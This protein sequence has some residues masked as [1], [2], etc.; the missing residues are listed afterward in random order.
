MQTLKEIE[1]RRY[2]KHKVKRL[3]MAHEYYRNNKEKCKARAKRWHDNNKERIKITLAAWRLKN[4]NKIGEQ[5]KAWQLNN[6][7]KVR[8]WRDANRDKL[9]AWALKSYYK[10]REKRAASQRLYNAKNAAKIAKRMAAYWVRIKES[11][12]ARRTEYA[13]EHRRASPSYRI[14]ENLR[15]RISSALKYGAG[16]KKCAASQQLAGCTMQKLK[17]HLESK[18]ADGM[19]WYNYGTHGWHI[20]HIRPCASF[21]LTKPEQQHEC[22]HWSNLQPLWAADNIRKWRHEAPPKQ[23]EA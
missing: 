18:F 10:H 2:L 20:D 8:A 14:G 9:K 4:K 12:R 7:D 3:N 17:Q 23:K 16:I 6:K 22:F 11:A 1:R 13:R 15:R 21:D 19:S 5:A